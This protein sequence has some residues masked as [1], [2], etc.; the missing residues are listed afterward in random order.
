MPKNITL[1]ISPNFTGRWIKM[2]PYII[3]ATKY[4]QMS[5]GCCVLHKF[6]RELYDLGAEVY[7]NTPLQNKKWSVPFADHK[8]ITELV[9]DGAIS[10]F[11]EVTR[12]TPY[13]GKTVVRFLLNKPGYF[14]GPTVYPQEDLI[15]QYS[16]IY[17]E[18]PE[19]KILMLTILDLDTMKDYKRP[20]QGVCFYVG[21][22]YA[23]PRI[24]ETDGATEI[25]KNWPAQKLRLAYVFQTS[26]L[27]ITYD[28]CTALI[29]E[30]R[31]CGCPVVIIPG[32]V[33]QE[34]IKNHE[35]GLDGIGFGMAEK[36]H[37]K[38]SIDPEKV[39]ERVLAGHEVFK[40]RLSKF[41]IDTQ[42]IAE[43]RSAHA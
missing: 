36:E 31:L 14:G 28:N 8:L 3:F 1:K 17:G 39:R 34:E 11:P 38:D 10:V 29:D 23:T 4:N 2:V 30:A 20:R 15:Y 12:G 7:L 21:K 43:Q 27:F 32:H 40:K 37:A 6:A 33:D 19:D 25:T 24:K 18:Y 22:G 42:D 16:R 41:I 5:G 13:H 26:E 35:I 9:T